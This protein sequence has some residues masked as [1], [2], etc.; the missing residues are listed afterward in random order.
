V[1]FPSEYSRRHHARLLG[2]DGPVIPDPIPLDRLVAADPEPKYATF[3]NPQPSKGMAV[4][5]RIA[6]VLNERR[7]DTPFLEGRSGRSRLNL[8][9]WQRSAGRGLFPDTST[10]RRVGS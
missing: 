8:P 10:R 1:I 9:R 6:V 5:A 2:L 3:I 7:P 4:F